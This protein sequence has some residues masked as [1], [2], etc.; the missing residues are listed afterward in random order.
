MIELDDYKIEKTCVYKGEEYLV[1]DNGAILR[2]L[3]PGQKP[4]KIDNQWSF[5]TVNPQNG[6]L[7]FA[8]ERVHRIVA[9]AFFGDPKDQKLIVDHIDT[10]RQNNRASNLRWITRLENVMLNKITRKKIEYKIGASVEEFLQNPAK[11]RDKLAN[12]DYSWMRRV[13]EEEARICLENLNQW[14]SRE[15]KED[16]ERSQRTGEWVF[17]RSQHAP[18]IYNPNHSLSRLARQKNWSTPTKFLCCPNE[19]SGSPLSSY[20]ENLSI[21]ATFC[22]NDYNQKSFIENFALVG[23]KILVLTELPDSGI[24]NYALA[25]VTFS[26]GYYIHTSMGTF[27]TLEGA[28]KQF[29]LAQGLEWTG[30]DSIDD[31]C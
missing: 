12:S 18:V 4:R 7:T 28:E 23:D 2:K 24:K 29:T 14:K 15:N 3:R 16:T 20:Y 6:Y 26:N 21:G 8:G 27:F 17:K 9:V 5:G 10:N 22:T 25:E 31:Y 11:Y 30:G 1:R 13:T 19:I